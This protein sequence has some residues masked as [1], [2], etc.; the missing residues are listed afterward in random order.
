MI[1]GYK[2]PGGER[3]GVCASKVRRGNA[4]ERTFTDPVKDHV[5]QNLMPPTKPIVNVNPATSNQ[6][7]CYED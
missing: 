5:V 2:T 3:M 1:L 4:S 7:L 6:H